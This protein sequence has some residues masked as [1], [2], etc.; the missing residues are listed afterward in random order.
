MYGSA[1]K[2]D[3]CDRIDYNPDNG[4]SFDSGFFGWIRMSVNMPR[5]YGWTFRDPKHSSEVASADLCSIACARDFL[6]YVSDC[7]PQD[8]QQPVE[9]ALVNE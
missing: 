1:I 3:Q 5:D 6:R 7:V 8:E 4:G 2:C 9:M